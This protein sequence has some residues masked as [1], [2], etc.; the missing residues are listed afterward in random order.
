MDISFSVELSSFE[1]GKKC[2]LLLWKRGGEE[3]KYESVEE[4][5]LERTNLISLP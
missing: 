4:I 3:K 1:F 2:H 5:P